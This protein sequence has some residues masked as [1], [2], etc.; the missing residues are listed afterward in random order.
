MWHRNSPARFASLLSNLDTLV[1]DEA[2][3]VRA[4]L[5]DMMAVAL[6]KYGPRR[7]DPFGG[8][9]LVL[10]GDLE[11]RGHGSSRRGTRARGRR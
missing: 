5:F 1:I 8:V 10:V 7:G 2:T 11:T 6:E 3:I 4:D 9:Q